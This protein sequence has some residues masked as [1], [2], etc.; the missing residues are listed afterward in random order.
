M[1]KHEPAS[2]SRYTLGWHESLLI[3]LVTT[4]GIGF[5]APYLHLTSIVNL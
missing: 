3:L 4:L 1:L 2:D 5:K